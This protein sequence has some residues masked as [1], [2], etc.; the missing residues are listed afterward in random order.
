MGKSKN[1]FT[2][3]NKDA[4]SK[5]MKEELPMSTLEKTIGLL[6]T[7]PDD[8][9]ETI[10]AFV[11][12]INSDAYKTYSESASIKAED[13]HRVSE[14]MEGLRILESFAGTLPEDFNYEQELEEAR[15]EK[16]GRFDRY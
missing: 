15:N 13:E 7:M 2:C 16:Y 9:I 8:K 1:Q 5:I 14:S 3:H 6:E 10:Y 4:L 11:R 12:F